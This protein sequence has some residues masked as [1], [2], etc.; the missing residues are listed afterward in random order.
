MTI[1]RKGSPKATTAVLYCRVSATDAQ[2]DSTTSLESQERT[3]RAAALAH[4]YTD[5]H[6]VIE[7]HTAATRLPELALALDALDA[8]GDAVDTEPPCGANIGT[9]AAVSWNFWPCFLALFLEFF[10]F[11][12]CGSNTK[13]DESDAYVLDKITALVRLVAAAGCT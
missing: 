5:V 4:G 6:V 1:K 9:R 8:L 3:L 12:D 13:T 11:L 7:R 2:S 10:P